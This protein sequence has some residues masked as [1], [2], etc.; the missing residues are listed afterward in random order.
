[1]TY[2]PFNCDLEFDLQYQPRPNLKMQT[3]HDFHIHVC[4]MT[5]ITTPLQDIRLQNLSALEFGFVRVKSNHA[6]GVIY[7]YD[8]WM[9]NRQHIAI[10]EHLTQCYSY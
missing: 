5:V 4:L 1:M 6:I 2:K 8:P 7:M 9:Y 10:S 3:P